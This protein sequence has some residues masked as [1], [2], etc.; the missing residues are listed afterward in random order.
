LLREAAL[1]REVFLLR[2]VAYWIRMR[3]LI[4]PQILCSAAG[5]TVFRI[6]D[7]QVSAAL[8]STLAISVSIVEKHSTALRDE[9]PLLLNPVHQR[10]PHDKEDGGVSEFRRLRTDAAHPLAQLKVPPR[11]HDDRNRML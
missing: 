10:R 8:V 9:F 11:H 2:E 5:G 1:L 4:T 6:T 3:I 7:R